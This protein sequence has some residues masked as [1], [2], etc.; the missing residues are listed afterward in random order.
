MELSRVCAWKQEVHSHIKIYEWVT[1]LG[2][3]ENLSAYHCCR[4]AVRTGY[5]DLIIVKQCLLTTEL[6]MTEKRF[7]AQYSSE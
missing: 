3:T 4:L 6:L 5:V 1:S 7:T 2:V